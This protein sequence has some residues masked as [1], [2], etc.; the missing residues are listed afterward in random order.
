MALGFEIGVDLRIAR[1]GVDAVQTVPRGVRVKS[2]EPAARAETQAVAQTRRRRALPE[3][4]G[5]VL[6]LDAR[7]E[8]RRTIRR[9]DFDDRLLVAEPEARDA[10]HAD[11]RAV[12]GH[13]VVERGF[14]GARAVG[15][16][17]RAHADADLDV[18]VARHRRR[19]HGPA[20]AATPLA[21]EKVLQDFP[22][23]VRRGIAVDDV[24]HFDH[25]RQRAAAEAVDLLHGE[26]AFGVGVGAGVELEMAAQRVDELARA[27]D[28]AGR[29][30]A[31]ADRMP[32][33]WLAAELAVER[34]DTYDGGRR[35]GGMRADVAQRRV[36]QI[37][38]ARLDRL[39]HGHD[40]LR[41]A[42]LLGEDAVE[43][44]VVEGRAGIAGG[45]RVHRT[46]S[47]RGR[48]G[49][50]RRGGRAAC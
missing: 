38:A 31:D 24:V 18:G 43:F 22:D 26:A 33:R 27:L 29:A 42:P 40:V 7:V 2:F 32:S 16:A 44:G 35:D 23:G 41:A 8:P 1:L 14:D 37:V 4:R 28:V 17:A 39:Q 50:G 11:G 6:G 47:L 34:R 3:D 5:H 9:F 10:P 36:R 12:R 25:G 13:G 49:G 19:R 20:G 15:D 30:D 45:V 46:P 48:R 21:V